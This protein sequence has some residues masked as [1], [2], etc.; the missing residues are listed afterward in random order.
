MVEMPSALKAAIAARRLLLAIELQGS[1][2][3][4]GICELPARGREGDPS[5][6]P[7]R[8]GR[9]GCEPGAIRLA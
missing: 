2:A 5:P 8:S 1:L 4:P 7:A 3:T 9:G 6:R